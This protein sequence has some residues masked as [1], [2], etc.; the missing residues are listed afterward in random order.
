MV[1]VLPSLG[2]AVQ[3]APVARLSGEGGR[4]VVWLSGDYDIATLTAL[5]ERLATAIGLDG[6]DVVVDLSEVQF[7]DAA[8]IGLLIRARDFLRSRSRHLRLR[9]PLRPVRRIL[10]VCDLT[11]MID[12]APV[13][14]GQA[15]GWSTSAVGSGVPVPPTDRADPGRRL[16]A[17]VFGNAA[18]SVS[19]G[20]LR[21]VTATQSPAVDVRQHE[22]GSN[23]M[24]RGGP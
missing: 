23:S 6:A 24:S 5:A 9:N 14:A 2:D 18:H 10:D 17:A 7:I 8:T 21:L 3:Q 12:A 15:M 1:T 4:T 11:G 22:P 20:R 16:S 13:D 19:P